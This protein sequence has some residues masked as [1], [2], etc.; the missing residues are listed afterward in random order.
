[1]IEKECISTHLQEK[2]RHTR[3]QKLSWNKVNATHDV[4]IGEDY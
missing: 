2:G 3:M 1:M 4:I